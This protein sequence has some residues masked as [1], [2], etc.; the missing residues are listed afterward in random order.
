MVV[1]AHAHT[2]TYIHIHTDSARPGAKQ[3]SIM[4]FTRPT[5][6]SCISSLFS[7]ARGGPSKISLNTPNG[8]P[9]VSFSQTG[10]KTFC[11]P[12]RFGVHRPI[13]TTTAL[14]RL[15]TLGLGCHQAVKGVFVF[16]PKGYP[17]DP[18]AYF[19]LV[20]YMEALICSRGDPP[21][22]LPPPTRV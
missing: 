6:G 4:A 7:P 9:E 5:S 2:Y 17:D 11:F 1:V 13:R 19:S 18:R 10:V 20:L 14:D 16:S 21:P 22:P 8:R 12:L 3:C 15:G